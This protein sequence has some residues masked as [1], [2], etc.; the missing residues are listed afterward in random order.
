MT[1]IYLF[2]GQGSQKVGMGKELFPLFPEEV[3]QANAILGYSIEQLCT[4]DP[5]QLLNRTDYTQPALYVVNA[6][7]YFHKVKETGVA[8]SY[9]AGHSLGEYNALLAGGVFDFQTGLKLVQKRGALM[10]Q[11][12]GGGMAA[13]LGMPIEKIRELLQSPQHQSIDVAN[14]NSPEQ[15]V[16]SGPAEAIQNAKADFDAAGAKRYIVLP[17]SGAFHSR[18]MKPS[19]EEFANFLKNFSFQAPKIPVIANVTAQPYGSSDV[20]SNMA[21]QITSSVR[22][23]ETIRWLLEKPEVDFEEIGPGRVLA[24]LLKQIRG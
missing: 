9:V 13:V 2:P 15:T 4:E 7:S 11:A 22:W 12:Q 8:P 14:F 19:Q 18:Y 3:S 21:S 17:V 16:I 20:I 24:G 10:A 1:K 23:V 6:L 5:Q